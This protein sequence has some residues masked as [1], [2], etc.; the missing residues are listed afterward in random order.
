MKEYK[1]REALK[2]LE[3]N[4][5]GAGQRHSIDVVLLVTIMATM[6]GYVGYRAVGDFVIRYKQ[7]LIAYLEVKK[8]RLPSFSTIRR[9]L[10]NIDHDA[11]NEIFMQWMNHYLVQQGQN[12]I[13]VDGK[14]IKGTKQA[15]EDKKLAHLVSFFKSDSKEILQAKQTASKSNEIPLVQEMLQTFPLEKMIITMDAMHCQEETLK[16]IKASGNEYLVQV[17]GNQKNS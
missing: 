17:K 9:V 8:D 16:A 3:D 5:R 11:F 6:S 12:W 13:S 15:H 4:R 14:A 2:G 7:E 1:L 10:M